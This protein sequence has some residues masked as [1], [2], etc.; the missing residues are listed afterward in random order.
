MTLM[1]KFRLGACDGGPERN[2]FKYFSI[3]ANEAS[4]SGLLNS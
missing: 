1:F 3:K 2:V 4:R